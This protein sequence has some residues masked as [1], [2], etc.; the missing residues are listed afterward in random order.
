[1][2]D[3]MTLS[4]DLASA[5]LELE[6]MV[7][8]PCAFAPQA[9]TAI[10]LAGRRPESDALQQLKTRHGKAAAMIAGKPML[11]HVVRA[12]VR[13]GLINE[14]VIT[15]EHNLTGNADIIA[16]AEGVPLCHV[17]AQT[18]VCGSAKAAFSRAGGAALI[19]T[20]DN[21]LLKPETVRTFIG[22]AAQ[23]E[24][25]SVGLVSKTTIDEKYP[26]SRRT[27]YR[28]GDDAVSGANLFYL[29][30]ENAGAAL[31]FWQAIEANRKR[32]WRILRA[33]G[34]STTLGMALRRFSLSQGFARASH[35]I[36][37]PIK[38]H[39]LQDAEAAMDVDKPDDFIAAEAILKA[40]QGTTQKPGKGAEK[41]RESFAV[42]DLDR[43][44]TR[45]GTFTPFLL[46]TR[47][48][49]IARMFLML[50]LLRHMALYKA[51]GISRLELKNRMLAITFRGMTPS[52]IEA[53]ARRFA[54]SILEDGLRDGCMLALAMH[55][56]E[57]DTMVL[58]T[59]SIDLYARHMADGLGFDHLVCTK[60]TY[61]EGDTTPVRIAGDN[62]Y[63]S[64]KYLRLRDVVL[65][66]D[67]RTREQV[68]IS[69]YSDHHA[70]MPI[71]EWADVPVM[72]SP[73]IRT[74]AMAVNRQMKIVEW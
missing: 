45:Y 61:T 55:K 72:V 26:E 8:Q 13:S 27:Y 37:C 74:H 40:R 50:R 35:I 42:F 66:G 58:A 65:K 2:H 63:G 52:E 3:S 15:S 41:T 4:S 54:T 69:F 60:T 16:A 46:S 62:C 22:S 34:W 44:L 47:K 73:G 43:T 68:F 21:P 39:L 30:G 56:M 49:M 19:T 6:S 64:G 51:G 67:A 70:D 29:R 32:P 9:C 18:S 53:A 25:F 38:Q 71:L 31:D 10:I 24:G 23:H 33:F 59:A 11:A 5:D 17:S 20:A 28:F 12:L 36:G 1:M 14:I 57:G 7:T 48:G